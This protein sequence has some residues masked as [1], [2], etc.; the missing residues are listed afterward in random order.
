LSK[1][2]RLFVLLGG[3]AMMTLAAA[4]LGAITTGWTH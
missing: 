2:V 3:F 1:T 4:L